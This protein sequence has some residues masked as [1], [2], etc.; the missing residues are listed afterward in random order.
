MERRVGRRKEGKEGGRKRGRAPI[1]SQ[2]TITL[3][4]DKNCEKTGTTKET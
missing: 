2:F 3:H 4:R 1:F